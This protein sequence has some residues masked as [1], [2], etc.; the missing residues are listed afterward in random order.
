MKILYVARH[1][2]AEPESTTGVDFDRR[3]AMRGEIEIGLVAAKARDLALGLDLIVASPAART[4]ATAAAYQRAFALGDA[5]F[6]TSRALYTTETGHL[7]ELVHALPAGAERV[8]VVGHNPIISRLAHWLAD[9][10]DFAE[11]DP[12]TIAAYQ[13]DVDTWG[14]VDPSLTRLIARLSPFD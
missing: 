11:F 6:K 1:A 4:L 9:S 13:I 12:A 5:Q 14:D 3:L 10:D 2:T 7:A 8:L